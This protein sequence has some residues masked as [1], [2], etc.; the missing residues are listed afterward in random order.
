TVK[1]D[2]P[3]KKNALT[4]KFIDSGTAYVAADKVDTYVDAMRDTTKKL[5]ETFQATYLTCK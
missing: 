2:A 4:D 1:T 5:F 3:F